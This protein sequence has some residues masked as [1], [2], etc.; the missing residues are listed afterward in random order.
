[1]FSKERSI[2]VANGFKDQGEFSSKDRCAPTS[3]AND[4]SAAH[5]TVDVERRALSVRTPLSQ[6]FISHQAGIPS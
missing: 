2:T 1:M 3:A 4:D 5:M 6:D